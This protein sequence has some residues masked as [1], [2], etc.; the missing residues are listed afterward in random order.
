MKLDCQH[1]KLHS[2]IT[3][4]LLM[5]GNEAVFL[6]HSISCLNLDLAC[7]SIY[8]YSVFEGHFISRIIIILSPPPPP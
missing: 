1:N 8:K 5:K 2:A 3:F 4:T 6:N 7:V